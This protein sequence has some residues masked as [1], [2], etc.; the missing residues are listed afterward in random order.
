MKVFWV[1]FGPIAKI[2][3][4]YTT[5]LMEVSFMA[6]NQDSIC[7][8]ILKDIFTAGYTGFVVTFMQFLNNHHFVWLKL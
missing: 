6:S 2:L 8:N 7:R 1:V 4:V 5:G 3:F